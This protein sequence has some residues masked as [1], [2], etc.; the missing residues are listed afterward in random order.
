M[1]E[2]L[3]NSLW[4]ITSRKCHPLLSILHVTREKFNLTTKVKQ[5]VHTSLIVARLIQMLKMQ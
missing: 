4:Q 3:L 2:L 1:V 5:L